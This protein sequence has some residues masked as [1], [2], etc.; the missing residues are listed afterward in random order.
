MES[1]RDDFHLFKEPSTAFEY[2][3]RTVVV[4]LHLHGLIFETSLSYWQDQPNNIDV[5]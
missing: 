5:R 4:N 3:S 2:Y 1:S